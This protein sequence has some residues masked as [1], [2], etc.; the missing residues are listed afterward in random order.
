DCVVIDGGY[1]LFLDS[2]IANN[3]H[4]AKQSLV[5]PIRK[6]CGSELSSH[7]AKYNSVLGSFRSAIESTFGEIGHLF[8]R[9]NGKSVIRVADMDTYTVQFKLPCVLY[10]MKKFVALGN[11]QT[12][13]HHT[14]WMQP[15][16][17]F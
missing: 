6:Q 7:E 12:A 14:F 11:I 16:F 4:L 3:P 9:F 1:T 15:S 2:V 5:C 17:D 10:N 13:E 8:Q